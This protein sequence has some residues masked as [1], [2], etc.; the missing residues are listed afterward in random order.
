MNKGRYLRMSP[1]KN[2]LKYRFLST[3]ALQKILRWRLSD[4]LLD[5]VL[6]GQDCAELSVQILDLS[7][8]LSIVSLRHLLVFLSC[9]ILS[10][11][12]LI[13]LPIVNSISPTN[14]IAAGGNAVTISGSGFLGTTSI[15]FGFRPAPSF[16]VVNDSTISAMVPP[17]TPGT[18]DVIVTASGQSSPSPNDFYTYTANGWRGIISSITPDQVALFDT[19][20]NTFGVSIPMLD[21]SL[22]SA[23]TPDGAYIYTA[24]RMSPGFSVIDAA[25]D[26]IIATVPTAVGSGAFDI[27][28]NPSGTRVYISNNISGFVTVVDTAT[29][30]VVTDI[31][32]QVNIGPLSITPD[33]STLYV[34]A[35]SSGTIIPI[36]TAT[37]TVGTSISTGVFAGK[38]S[39]LPNGQKA[40]IPVFNTDEVLVMDVATQIITNTIALSPGSFPYGSSIL[41]DGTT[42]YVVNLV[43]NSCSVIDV[44]SETVVA[45]IPL[46]PPLPINAGAFWAVATPDSKTVYILNE[47][48]SFVVPIDTQTNT[49]GVPFDGVAGSFQDMVISSD[50]AP[51]ASFSSTVQLAGHSTSFNASASF[52][53]IGTIASYAWDFGDGTA[54]TTFSPFINHTY[55]TPGNYTA[56]LTVTN[57]SGT[58]T[59]QVFSSGFMSKNGGPVAVIS[60]EVQS[61]QPTP[62]NL[63]GFQKKC[64][65]PSQTNYINV[66]TWNAPASGGVP[67]FYEIFRDSPTNLIGT[68]PGNGLLTFNDPNRRKNTIYTYYLVVVSAS[69]VRSVPETVIIGSN[70]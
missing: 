68:V 22:A 70:G 18:V 66:L 17:G 50:P 10:C 9:W 47:M 29:N 24:N 33:G 46:S 2:N 25:T 41:P 40:F 44:A 63:E 4:R 57:S 32:V 36:D 43:Q 6:K 16:I 20:G 13:G 53:P 52:S 5:P 54:A 67:A 59:T 1:D 69:G 55:A 35:L 62:T 48:N 56:T 61:Q 30:T 15:D 64:R 49:V 26:T 12:H 19:T 7:D 27:V 60:H 21:N 28:V 34:S 8:W 3:L 39:I 51:I 65:Y 58:S 42:L 14:G 38:V 31:P 37:N 23:I 45:T 11:Q